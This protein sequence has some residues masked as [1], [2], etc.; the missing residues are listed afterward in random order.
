MCF[1]V[2]ILPAAHLIA[3]ETKFT[4]ITNLWM[5]ISE[6]TTAV[7]QYI[8]TEFLKNMFSKLWKLFNLNLLFSLLFLLVGDTVLSFYLHNCGVV[9][10]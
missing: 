8:F 5:F 6:D 1:N 4:N 3:V 2:Q 7:R 9:G 10:V